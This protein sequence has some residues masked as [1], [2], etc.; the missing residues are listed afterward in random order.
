M[1]NKIQGKCKKNGKRKK[2]RKKKFKEKF[3]KMKKNLQRKKKKNI[4]K[5]KL[6]CLKFYT[7]SRQVIAVFFS[8]KKFEI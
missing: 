1:W 5:K 8:F 6:F 4:E 3:P 2:L 7:I